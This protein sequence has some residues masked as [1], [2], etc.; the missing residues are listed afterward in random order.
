VNSGPLPDCHILALY[1]LPENEHM[2]ALEVAL[3]RPERCF[4]KEEELA[5]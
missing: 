3:D 2:D 4:D 5:T 1:Q